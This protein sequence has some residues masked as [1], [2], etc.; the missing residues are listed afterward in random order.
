MMDTTRREKVRDAF[1]V[2]RKISVGQV[3]LKTLRVGSESWKGGEIITH[4]VQSFKKMF[5]LKK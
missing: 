4:L 2:V 1:R 3:S 5:Y